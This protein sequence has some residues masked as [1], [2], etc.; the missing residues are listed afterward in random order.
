[1][2]ARTVRVG[3]S[4]ARRVRA[5]ATH[6]GAWCRFTRRFCNLDCPE[7]AKEREAATS[8]GR[9]CTNGVEIPYRSPRAGTGS[10]GAP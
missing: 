4:T 9:Y 10:E 6:A 2:R 5:E 1:M 8:A 7:G 3:L